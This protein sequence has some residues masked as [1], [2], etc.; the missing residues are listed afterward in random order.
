MVESFAE[1]KVFKITE[2][3]YHAPNNKYWKNSNEISRKISKIYFNYRRVKKIIKIHLF[4]KNIIEIE[5]IFNLN[6]IV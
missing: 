5:F 6:K 4:Y 3:L 2:E 1:R